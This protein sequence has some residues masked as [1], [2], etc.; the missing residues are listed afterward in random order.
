MRRETVR[1]FAHGRWRFVMT[2]LG[3]DAAILDGNHHACPACGGKDRFRFDDKEGR[4]TWFC[5]SCGAGDGIQ[6]VMRI[7]GENFSKSAKQVEDI[8]QKAGSLPDREFKSAP[9]LAMVK[10]RLN[11]MWREA[12]TPLVAAEYLRGRGLD[13]LGDLLDIRGHGGLPLYMNNKYV[14]QFPAMLAMIRNAAGNPISIHRT[15]VTPEGRVKKMTQAM[16]TIT[17][18]AIRLRPIKNGLLVVGEGIETTIAGSNR[19]GGGA[20][21]LMN[22]G[23]MH[24]WKPPHGV[25]HLIICADNDSNFVGAE[26]AFTLARRAMTLHKGIRVDVVMPTSE[27]KDM[28]DAQFG[29]EVGKGDHIL[30]VRNGS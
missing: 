21:A 4:G 30:R 11:T 27:G 22:A 3:V 24:Q 1:D 5:N 15:Y 28:L 23:N 2:Q 26:A 9:D 7:T 17:G 8:L 14:G 12:V 20:W 18:A 19:Y 16:E 29:I 10:T 6:L 25:E 13:N